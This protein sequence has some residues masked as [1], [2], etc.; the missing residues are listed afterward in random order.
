[1]T[2]GAGTQ[3]AATQR[4]SDASSPS[5]S[6]DSDSDSSDSDTEMAD[7]GDSEDSEDS[8]VV[9]NQS[10]FEVLLAGRMQPGILAKAL[11]LF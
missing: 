10:V 1:M 5:S 2:A 3:D 8:T 11:R 4:D 9:F 6:G 7:T